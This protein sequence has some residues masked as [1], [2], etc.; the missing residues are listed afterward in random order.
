MQHYIVIELPKNFDRYKSYFYQKIIL[1]NMLKHDIK[2]DVLSG[3]LI[4]KIG[5][6]YTDNTYYYFGHLMKM[7]FSECTCEVDSFDNNGIKT[8]VYIFKNIEDNFYMKNIEDIDIFDNNNEV[9]IENMPYEILT[10]KLNDET[11]P[12]YLHRLGSSKLTYILLNIYETNYIIEN[13]GDYIDW[14]IISCQT[15]ISQENINKYVN[16]LNLIYLDALQYNYNL[17]S[18]TTA[19]KQQ[20]LNKMKDIEEMVNTRQPVAEEKVNLALNV[21]SSNRHDYIKKLFEK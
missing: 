14:N 10:L 18:T 11:L 16:Q 20:Y 21:I 12:Y 15:D 4:P 1:M 17:N 2:D 13:Y 5:N 9:K 6:D 19:K 7:Y 8:E 3:V